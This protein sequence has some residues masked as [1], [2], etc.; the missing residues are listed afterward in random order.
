MSEDAHTS[1][2]RQLDSETALGLK[3]LE[4]DHLIATS[5]EQTSRLKKEKAAFILNFSTAMTQN[6]TSAEPTETKPTEESLPEPSAE[7]EG[8]AE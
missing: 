4:F 2:G 8:K 7:E 6:A 5:E 1:E 3:L